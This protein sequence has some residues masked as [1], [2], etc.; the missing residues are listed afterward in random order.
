MF[1]DTLNYIIIIR[2]F[3]MKGFS[4]FIPTIIYYKLYTMWLYRMNQFI[5]NELTNLENTQEIVIN[6]YFQIHDS[7]IHLIYQIAYNIAVYKWLLVIIQ[8]ILFRFLPEESHQIPS[9]SFYFLQTLPH[10]LKR[11]Q[12]ENTQQCHCLMVLK[13]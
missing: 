2:Q 4:I 1:S 9:Y 10:K 12:L 5:N 13:F 3:L 11:L 8:T 7:N 6:S